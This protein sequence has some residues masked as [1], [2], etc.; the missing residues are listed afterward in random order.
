M[1]LFYRAVSFVAVG[2]WLRALNGLLALYRFRWRIRLF[3]WVP[4]KTY[5]MLA[6]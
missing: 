1:T 6:A 3:L 4:D 2:C 5:G